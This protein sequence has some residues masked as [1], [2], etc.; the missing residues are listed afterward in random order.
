MGELLVGTLIG[1][2]ALGLIGRPHL[3]LVAALGSAEAAGQAL[4]T[5]YRLLAELGAI[6]LLF[7]MGLHERYAEL[8]RVGGRALSVA[9]VE[10]TVSFA[11]GFGLVT[12]GL[13]YSTIEGL[14]GH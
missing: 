1:P 3:D 13:N 2:Y 7:Y 8:L 5:T 11:L 12:F 14:L 9:A 10:V 4:H 6:V